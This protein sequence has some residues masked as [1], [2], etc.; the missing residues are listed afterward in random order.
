MTDS[1]LQKQEVNYD[2][3][4]FQDHHALVKNDKEEVLNG[5]Q[6]SQKTIN[7]KFFYDTYGSE[8]FE[9]ITTL[10]EYYPTR[11]ERS[12][13][14]D[15]AQEI[16]S[17]CSE[18]CVFIEPG[19]G[20]SEKIRLLLDIIK[21][22]AYVPMDIA[23]E[24]L[25]RSAN[26]LAHQFSWLLV[27]AL[28][29]DF[30]QLP[31]P[32]TDL[33]I[34]KRVIFY[35]GSTLGNMKPNEALKFLIQLRSWLVPSVHET[36][37]KEKEGGVLIGID[38]HKSSTVLSAA[39]NDEQGI[40]AKFNLNVLDHI[41]Q[42]FQSNIDVN[43]FDHHAFYNEEQ[44]R[45][46]MHLVSQEMHSVILN[47]TEVAFLQGETIHTENSYKYTLESFS[48]LVGKAGFSIEKTWLDDQQLFS[49]HYLQL[50]S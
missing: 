30:A 23:G 28:C 44:R 49:V 43:K 14:T 32:P 12:I 11:T 8:L 35:P 25:H 45:I 2:N 46:E 29:A 7:P 27:H 50:N 33:P 22:K 42:L 17:Y 24:F 6:Q 5:L 16:A 13:L 18:G 38:L 9:K 10:P 20:S 40:T 34:G 15:N 26:K 1:A 3:V 48:E 47:K 36:E 37:G 39:Y 31:E 19:S 21:P 4:V 41:N